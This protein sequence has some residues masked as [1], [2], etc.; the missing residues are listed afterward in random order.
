MSSG[1]IR[2][3]LLD[4]SEIRSY[5]GDLGVYPDYAADTPPREGMFIILRWGVQ[6]YRREARNGPTMMTLWAHQPKEMG[7][8]TTGL[9]VLLDRCQE[10]L[11]G[12]EHVVGEDDVR[13]TNAIFTGKGGVV[14]DPGFETYARS[15][16]YNV[17]LHV[18]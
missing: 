9:N 4:D 15:S 13:V 5:V 7:S 3:A 6:N 8:D 10:V 17:L 18:V 2:K 11:E 12:M 1:A 16:G 14:Y